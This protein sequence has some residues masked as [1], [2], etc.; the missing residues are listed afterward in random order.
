[1]KNKEKITLKK[2]DELNKE[3]LYR[4]LQMRAEI[5]I[6]EQQA[7]YLDPDNKDQ[8]AWHLFIRNRKGKIVGY[9]RIF[10]PG[11]YFSGSTCIGRVSVDKSYRNQGL[12]YVLMQKS[13]DFLRQNYP[14]Y[15]VEI[16]A[17]TYLIKFYQSLGFVQISNQYLEDG[18]PHVRMKLYFNDENRN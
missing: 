9:S 11:G 12:G 7:P 15:P 13:I 18:L 2:F 4:I 17:Q 5:F 8:I 3:E 16:S 14:E 10:G 6:K 1:M